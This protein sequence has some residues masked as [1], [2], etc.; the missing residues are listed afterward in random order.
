VA[1][2]LF[3]TFYS[4]SARSGSWRLM[5]SYGLAAAGSSLIILAMLDFREQGNSRWAIHLGRISYGIYVYHYFLIA[6]VWRLPMEILEMKGL[7][8][9]VLRGVID[10]ALQVASPLLIAWGLAELSYRFFETPFLRLKRRYTVIASQPQGDSE[11][12]A[13]PTAP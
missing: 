6:L 12:L 5:I 3:N 11:S 4:S 8:S 7:H 13:T 2:S 9:H 10:F 1:A